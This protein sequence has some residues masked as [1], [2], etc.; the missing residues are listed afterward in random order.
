MI[1]KQYLGIHNP[2]PTPHKNFSINYDVLFSFRCVALVY[3]IVNEILGVIWFSDHLV[4]AFKHLTEWGYLMCLG[5]TAVLVIEEPDKQV[6]Y[7]YGSFFHLLL[8]L[9]L[10]ITI[11]Y[12]TFI[13]PKYIFRNKQQYYLYCVKHAYPMIHLS[14]EFVFNNIVF[15]SSSITTLLIF[16]AV[17]FV[18]NIVMALRF[19]VV[20]YKMITWRSEFKRPD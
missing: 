15:T 12:W 17:Y 2:L 11:F 7:D 18:W 3:Y 20:V 8:S 9:E 6:T 1:Q 19:N 13:H 16:F 10:L 5:F 14:L 4:H